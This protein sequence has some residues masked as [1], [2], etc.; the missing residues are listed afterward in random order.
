VVGWAGDI[1]VT[2][3]RR[4]ES[5]NFHN[6]KFFEKMS[7]TYLICT[8][9]KYGHNILYSMYGSRIPY[10]ATFWNVGSRADGLKVGPLLFYG[11]KIAPIIPRYTN[12]Q[13]N[14]RVGWLNIALLLFCVLQT[15]LEVPRYTY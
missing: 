4:H 2:K 11:L 8:F 9:I 13:V 6:K 7:N 10:L 1:K 14:L 3:I 5:T 15:T 12:L